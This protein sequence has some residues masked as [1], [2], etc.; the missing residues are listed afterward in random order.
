MFSLLSTADSA[1]PTRSLTRQFQTI[2]V[3]R[4]NHSIDRLVFNNKRATDHFSLLQ[5]I[6]LTWVNQMN[7]FALTFFV[8]AVHGLRLTDN[9]QIVHTWRTTELSQEGG[10][11]RWFNVACTQCRWGSYAEHVVPSRSPCVCR[12]CLEAFFRTRCASCSVLQIVQCC[13]VTRTD[14]RK[15]N[16]VL[17]VC[18]KKD[19]IEIRSDFMTDIVCP[20]ECKRW[21]LHTCIT[22]EHAIASGYL[23]WSC[24]GETSARAHDFFPLKT[25]WRTFSEIFITNCAMGC[26]SKV[27][28]LCYES[29]CFGEGNRETMQEKV[30]KT[31][32][33]L[34][35]V[36]ITSILRALAERTQLIGSGR[37]T[38]FPQLGDE[39]GDKYSDDHAENTA[40]EYITP[41][42]FVVGDARQ[43]D[44]DGQ[45]DAEE[46]YH[47]HHCDA[48]QRPVDTCVE[49]KL[50]TRRS[51]H[52]VFS[53]NAQ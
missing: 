11:I 37:L 13:F 52:N 30:H 32:T 27:P 42:M 35:T 10:E 40:G 38:T 6:S 4:P 1:T 45:C 36:A 44:E 9:S 25:I 26:V 43:A 31:L 12:A 19:A 53:S 22:T 50:N 39:G 20:R 8:A 15:L 7:C 34:M 2:A 47:W 29:V 41:V 14:R 18:V 33:E 24:L 48:R 3:Q 51:N 49:V 21:C 17:C 5:L 23:R 16:M 46:L 28:F